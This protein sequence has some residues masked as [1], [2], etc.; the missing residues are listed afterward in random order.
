M[1]L[2]LEQVRAEVWCE[3]LNCGFLFWF[4][5]QGE[6]VERKSDTQIMVE[7]VPPLQVFILNLTK[8]YLRS[9]VAKFSCQL[10]KVTVPFHTNTRKIDNFEQGVKIVRELLSSKQ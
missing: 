5:E 3:G 4:D 1:E 2:K 6:T 8:C 10:G 7:F 9:G